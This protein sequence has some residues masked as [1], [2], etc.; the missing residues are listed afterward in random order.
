MHEYSRFLIGIPYHFA[1]FATMS[2][3][4]K[5]YADAYVYV[6]FGTYVH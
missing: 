5:V 1:Y 2:S 3:E 6:S 4:Q